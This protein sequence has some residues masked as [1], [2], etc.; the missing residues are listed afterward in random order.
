MAGDEGIGA[1]SAEGWWGCVP[2]ETAMRVTY[3]D[4]DSEVTSDV[5]VEGPKVVLY[6]HQGR[7]LRREIGFRSTNADTR[8]ID[9]STPS[10]RGT[11][12]R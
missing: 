10:G 12:A 5:T 8:R 6:D 4:N 3:H 9:S 11:V 1:R 7:A 2:T